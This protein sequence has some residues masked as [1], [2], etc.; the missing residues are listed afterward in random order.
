[1]IRLIIF[2]AFLLALTGCDPDLKD[3]DRIYVI[4]DLDGGYYVVCDRTTNIA[5]L[6]FS[7]A[8]VASMTAYLNK[9]GN[10]YKCNEVK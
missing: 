1:M 10:P 4:G 5:Y 8:Y 2:I 3:S 9:D 6:K 7:A